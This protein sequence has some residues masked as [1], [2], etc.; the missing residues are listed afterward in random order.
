M[1]MRTRIVRTVIAEKV[2]IAHFKLFNAFN[3]VRIAYGDWIDTLAV[4]IA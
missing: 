2:D 3:F 1:I 4:A